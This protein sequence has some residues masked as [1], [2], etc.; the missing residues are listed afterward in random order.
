MM[1]DEERRGSGGG[2]QK[3][4]KG[5]RKQ[6]KTEEKPTRGT[7]KHRGEGHEEEEEES[8]QQQQEK[9]NGGVH[10]VVANV[11][12]AQMLAQ[13]RAN[14]RMNGCWVCPVVAAAR[15]YGFKDATPASVIAYT[16]KEDKAESA[17]Y[18]LWKNFGIGTQRCL[19]DKD[20][21]AG[22]DIDFW[23][24]SKLNYANE[25]THDPGIFK[26]EHGQQSVN[27]LWFEE[28]KKCIKSNNL[29]LL[30]GK[31][32]EE[33]EQKAHA[34]AT[35][36]S[37]PATH[38][39]LL[40]GY[41]MATSRRKKEYKLIVKDPMDETPDRVI[42]AALETG[43]SAGVSEEHYGKMVLV[44]KQANGTS[45]IDR[46]LLLECYFIRGKADVVPARSCGGGPSAGALLDDPDCR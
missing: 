9:E 15:Y 33:G 37:A 32:L 16:G 27:E 18:A 43:S 24:S 7:K 44:T 11:H 31:R 20:W 14:G 42:E 29:A 25:N 34:K 17:P 28:V 8:K 10:V 41:Q 19:D 38:Y 46:F 36:S 35:G 4:S 23:H 1:A 13:P 21:I 2:G 3:G 30:L 45:V 39:L 40:C 12:L 26:E 5:K 6:G 22:D